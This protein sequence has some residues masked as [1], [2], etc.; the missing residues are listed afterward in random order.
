M[1]TISALENIKIIFV[2]TGIVGLFDSLYLTY[3]HLKNEVPPCSIEG[4]ETVLTSVYASIYGFP[5]AGLGALYYISLLALF[6]LYIKYK[7]ASIT[8]LIMVATTG[9]FLVSLSLI[10]LQLFVIESIC[11]YCMVSAATSTILFVT[12]IFLVRLVKNDPLS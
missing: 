1:N 10:Y 6:A 8:H 11:L 4:C 9:G 7:K 2:S 12:S 3:E 5:L